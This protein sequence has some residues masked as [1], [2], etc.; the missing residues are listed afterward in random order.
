MPLCFVRGDIVTPVCPCLFLSHPCFFLEFSPLSP[1]K[2]AFYYFLCCSYN[3]RSIHPLRKRALS[4]R[5][6]RFVCVAPFSTHIS[7]PFVSPLVPST[8]CWLRGRTRTT[9]GR[10]VSGG[11]HPGT[12]AVVLRRDKPDVGGAMGWEWA[13]PYPKKAEATHTSS[14][15]LLSLSSSEAANHDNSNDSKSKGKAGE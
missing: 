1:S 9:Q 5:N 2:D 10:G 7:L 11:K 15:S 8:L 13:A 6:T 12:R 4:G 14:L 3:N